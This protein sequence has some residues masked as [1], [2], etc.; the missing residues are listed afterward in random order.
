MT[1]Y[2]STQEAQ[3][4]VIPALFPEEEQQMDEKL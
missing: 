3:I 2:V 1:K 4:M